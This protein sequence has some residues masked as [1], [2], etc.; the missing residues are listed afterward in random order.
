[1]EPRQ[2]TINRLEILSYNYPEVKLVADVSSG[3]YIRTLVEDIAKAAGTV[4]YTTQLRRTS[5]DRFFVADAV[6]VQTL[7][8]DIINERLIDI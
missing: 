6:A 8:E 1:M 5:I 2:V 3:T 4:A 7:N